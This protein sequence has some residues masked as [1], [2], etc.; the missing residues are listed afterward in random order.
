VP[1]KNSYGENQNFASFQ[2]LK[3]IRALVA[4]IAIIFVVRLAQLQ[5]LEGSEYLIASDA[6]AIKRVRI[7]PF[8]G[9]IFDRK[10]KLIVNNEA[11]F[12][13]TLTPAEFI[14][15]SKPL[16]ASLLQKDTS[17]ID[18][19]IKLA[20]NFSPYIPAKIERD[21]EF[22]KLAV[23]SEY[24]E[25]LYGVNISSESKRFYDFEVNMAHLLGY[26]K[27]ITKSELEQYKN[28]QPGDVI[29][30]QGIEKS[31]E[32]YLR[33]QHGFEFV[34][35]NKYGQKVAKFDN[36]KNDIKA[37]SGSDLYL[38]IDLEMQVLAEKL[39]EGKRGA[40]V[41]IDPRTGGVLTFASKPDYDLKEFSGKISN[42]YYSKV[43]N[44]KD[45]P[46]LPRALASEYPPGS[47]W[48]MVIAAA[49]LQEKLI[50][51]NS[52]F[53]CV[54]G[55]QYGN[56]FARCLGN[57][58]HINVKNAIKSSCNAFFYQLALKLGAERIT[59]YGR[60]FGFGVP[61]GI[62][63]PNERK[64]NYPTFEQMQKKWGKNIP[65]G[66]LM[67]FGIGQG[68]ILVTPLQLAAYTAT[69]ANGG[70]YRTP[71][72]GNEVKDTKTGKKVK[73]Y[74][75][76]LN[77]GFDKKVMDLIHQGM[78]DVVNAPGG[79]A[80]LARVPDIEVCGKTS[81]AQNPHGL[82]HGWFVCFAPREN[83]EIAIAVLVENAGSGGRGAAPLAKE[84]MMQYFYPDRVKA[85][86]ALSIIDNNNLQPQ[87]IDI[88]DSISVE[89]EEISLPVENIEQ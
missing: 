14:A 18:G 50:D 72:I 44:D 60:L 75:D 40:I 73:I 58:G 84:V 80:S 24:L 5:L 30:K 48:K 39:L 38:N 8:R 3:F 16:L 62:D 89:V 65:G 32:E 26:V 56:R 11:S 74:G 21:I 76:S 67:N 37:V 63:L 36:G 4:F 10:G 46:L 77:L 31:Y 57:H 28:Y 20:K 1:I 87:F 71:R 69:L 27:E 34:A 23:F 42:Q 64:G 70:I 68:E 82:A 51:E 66:I 12:A 59:K 54:G 2:R 52:T 25:Y 6:Q 53:V 7:E 85:T 86:D 78:S 29:G 83:P 43:I 35:V 79:T 41:A 45:K 15:E 47:A 13:V 22:S 55:Y 49:G 19:I 88:Q 81:T 33:G 9:N 17:E 61:S